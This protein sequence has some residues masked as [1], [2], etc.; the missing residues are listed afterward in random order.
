M[1]RAVIL[2]A[3]ACAG[4]AHAAR[5]A[6]VQ[7]IRIA[8]RAHDGRA[9]F[10]YVLL[11]SWYSRTWNPSIPLLI[12]PHGRGQT[13]RANAKL[14][15][16]LPTTGGFAVINPD[17]EG[18]RIPLYSWG[19]RGDVDDLAKMPSILERTL[20]WVH[21]R[22]D[23]VYAFGGSMGGQ[24]TL[25]LLARH[26][27]LLAGAAAFDPVADFAYQYEQ[28]HLIKCQPWDNCRGARYAIGVVLPNLP[29]L[30]RDE[31]GGTPQSAPKEF[32]ARSPITYAKELAFSR[33]PLQIWWSSVDNTIL[34]Q[35]KRQAGMLFWK[36]A[37]LNPRA[38]VMGFNGL[39]M[40]SH[41]MQEKSLLPLSLATFGLLPAKYDRAPRSLE[42]YLP[43]LAH[44]ESPP[45]QP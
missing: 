30:A 11:P 35:D 13:G 42:I 36:L 45:R 38:P 7:Q 22:R 18:R 37:A 3:L 15:G 32:A 14:W 34:D 39:W 23:K 29:K 21:I 40:H 20:P 44:L 5:A 25:L 12:S 16:S 10:A 24:E 6:D 33:V 19:Y 26:P 1:K 17:G 27:T 41:E 8:Y 28:F 4:A 9:R 31:V 43:A 2:V